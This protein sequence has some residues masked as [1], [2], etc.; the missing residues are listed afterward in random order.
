M[1]RRRALAKAFL[2]WRLLA[3]GG[4]WV[5]AQTPLAELYHTRW[6]ARDGAPPNITDIRLGPDG[7]IWVASN[8][9]LFRFDGVS[10]SPFMLPDGSGAVTQSIRAMFSTRDGSIWLVYPFL[11]IERIS[12]NHVTK[13]TRKEGLQ[14]HSINWIT[15]DLDGHFWIAGTG[16]LQMIEGSAI[17]DIGDDYQAAPK[18]VTGL[19]A[20]SAGDLWAASPDGISVLPRHQKRFIFINKTQGVER[21][22]CASSSGTGVWCWT[23]D[24][25]IT[26]FVLKDGRVGE[27]PLAKVSAPTIAWA[28]DER[29]VWVGTRHDGLKRFSISI[30][31]R[32][33]TTVDSFTQQDGL[34]SNFPFSILPDREGSLWIATTEGIDHFRRSVFAGKDFGDTVTI[35]QD[36]PPSHT[37]L[38]TD[39]IIDLSV[40]TNCVHRSFREHILSVYSGRDGAVWIGTSRLWRY[41][42]GKFTTFPLPLEVQKSSTGVFAI[43]QD[44]MGRLWISIGGIRASFRQAGK[45]WFRGDK[46]PGF[47]QV[48][49]RAIY[50]DPSGSLWFGF[51]RGGVTQLVGDRA[52]NYGPSAGLD[53]GVVESFA[54]SR[55]F[56][57]AGGTMGLAYLK[58]GHFYPVHLTAGAPQTVTGL[59]FTPDGALWLNSNLGVARITPEEVASTEADPAHPMESRRFDSFDGLQGVTDPESGVGSAMMNRDGRL[60]ISTRTNLQWTDP[61]HIPENPLAPD[62]WITHWKADKQSGSW[63]T[64]PVRVPS[65]LQ[66]LQI[67]YTANSLLI[68][69]R[70]KFRYRLEGYEDGWIDAG[71][72]RQAFYSKV[73]PGTYTFRVIACNDSGVWSKAGSNLVLTVPPTLFQTVLF[74][75]VC[76]LALACL[77]VLFYRWRILHLTTRVKE[78]LF[79]RVSERE[80]VA[81]ELHDTFFQSIQ[82]LLLRFN[83]A[84]SAL[85]PESPYRKVFED[86]L[87]RSDQVMREGRELVLDLRN[88][89]AKPNDLSAVL[90]DF[91]RQ[92]QNDHPCEFEIIVNGAV[93]PLHAAVC[94]EFSIIGKEAIYNA[95]LHANARTV[96]VEIHYERHQIRMCIRDNGVGIDAHVL[97]IGRREGHWG[98]PGMRERASKIGATLNIWSRPGAGT[99]IEVRLT[100]K[101]AFAPNAR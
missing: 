21:S 69:E 70:V 36:E 19:V 1:I 13:F 33:A 4:A 7:L 91:G 51:V 82:G 79:E 12:N 66:S 53:V 31:R 96:E 44:D 68:P 35:P 32:H 101:I 16:G 84:T 71:T 75:L 89:V 76:A 2:L 58:S 26:H 37:L 11:L 74:K 55:G 41:D 61:L 88:T 34:T 18:N 38:G 85:P 6:T 10:F 100:S 54:S 98:L 62:V 63:P 94:K 28:E 93:Q 24:G 64:T 25:W 92:L 52:V 8:A 14:E 42:R 65:D 9:G 97:K 56:L 29:T 49:A 99:E 46:L 87:L 17:H 39:C 83:T 86:A 78:R 5:E 27:F 30:D 72:R 59:I 23:T 47:P 57:W 48:M 95:F 15:E 60:Y 43:G 80:H 67:D 81:R 20:D 3:L 77:L 22:S 45:Q 90:A 50:K 40:S 73:P